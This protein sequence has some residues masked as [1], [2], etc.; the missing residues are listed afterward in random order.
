[1][2]MLIGWVLAPFRTLLAIVHTA[3]CCVI[4]LLAMALN[5]DNGPWVMWNLGRNLWSVP[6]IQWVLGAKLE[7]EVHPAAQELADSQQGVVLVANHCSL[8]DINAAFAGSPTPIVFLSKASIRKVP[9]LGKLN[10]LAGTVFVERGNRASSEVAV[11]QLTQTLLNG[12]SVLV[13]P[14][15]SRSTDGQLQPFK[16][17]AFHLAKAA[18]APVVPMH[19]AGTW[20]RLGPGQWL[21]APARQSIRVRVGAPIK[22]K[23]NGELSELLDQSTKSLM[24]LIN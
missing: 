7:V 18:N 17:G 22:E 13:F 1:M 5:K 8:L 12:R 15:G 3:I 20:E 24:Q 11:K 19:I 23:D 9:L 16:K 4:G 14:E 2:N 21:I 6:L 10:E